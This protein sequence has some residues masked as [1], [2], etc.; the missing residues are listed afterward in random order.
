MGKIK[1]RKIMIDDLWEY[2]FYKMPTS[3]LVRLAEK[4]YKLELNNYTKV[5]LQKKHNLA[6]EGN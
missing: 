6:F 3:E 4:Q 1:Q 5:A 2:D